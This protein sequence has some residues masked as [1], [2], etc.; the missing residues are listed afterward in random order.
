MSKTIKARIEQ[1]ETYNGECR[2]VIVPSWGDYVYIDGKQ[3]ERAEYEPD[4]DEKV[5][6]LTWG[7]DDHSDN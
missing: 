7:E 1:L 2:L 3:V 5:I 6:K 4:P